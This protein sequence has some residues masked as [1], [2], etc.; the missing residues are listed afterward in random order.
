MVQ[1]SES[2]SGCVAV[3][4]WT[5][6]FEKSFEDKYQYSFV[7]NLPYLIW[8]TAKKD[9]CHVR[10]HFFNH[11]EDLFEKAFFHQIREVTT[12]QNLSFTGHL[13]S[14]HL[15]LDQLSR[16]GDGMRQYPYFDIPG[17]DVLFDRVELVTAKQ[18]QSIVRQYGK[19]GMMSELYGVTGWDFD[20]KCLKMQGDWQAAL[21]VTLRVPHLSWMS[22]AGLAKRDYPASFNYQSPWYKEFS[23][24]ENHFA[25]LNTV[26]TRGKGRFK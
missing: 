4:A 24:L 5:Y 18:T 7:D 20:F 12:K 13:M 17:M 23:Y 15:L 16:T 2:N 6:G 14:E 10:Y 8:D 21:G 11:V 19:K 25:R 22:M 1:M 3:Y 26:L 9:C